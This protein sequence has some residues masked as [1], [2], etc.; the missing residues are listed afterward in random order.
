MQMAQ[1]RPESAEALNARKD[2]MESL[3]HLFEC[4]TCKAFPDL[5]TFDNVNQGLL[6]H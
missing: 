1:S 2:I 5:A 4:K 3:R 6:I